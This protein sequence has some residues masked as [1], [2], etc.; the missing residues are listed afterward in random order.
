MMPLNTMGRLGSNSNMRQNVILIPK[1]QTR[2]SKR[3]QRHFAKVKSWK[4]VNDGTIRYLEYLL[5]RLVRFRPT[6]STSSTTAR[7]SVPAIL[8]IQQRRLSTWENSLLIY[9]IEG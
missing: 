3:L 8:W 4:W 1:E 2:K 6:T 5:V 9:T 7:L